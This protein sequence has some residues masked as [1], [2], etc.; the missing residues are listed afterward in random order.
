MEDLTL[1]SEEVMAGSIMFNVDG[2]DVPVL[3]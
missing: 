3:E 2:S 1:G